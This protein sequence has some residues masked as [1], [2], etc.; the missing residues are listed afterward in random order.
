MA[1]TQDRIAA[2]ITAAKT[3]ED[4]LSSV[5]SVIELF[6]KMVCGNVITGADAIERLH[7]QFG[8]KGMPLDAVA[9]V[10]REFTRYELTHRRNEYMKE[11]Q[12]KRRGASRAPSSDTGGALAASSDDAASANAMSLAE[13]ETAIARAS[14]T[15]SNAASA[16]AAPGAFGAPSNDATTNLPNNAEPSIAFDAELSAD[17]LL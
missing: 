1:I 15:P 17:D 4:R 9:V 5:I 7:S 10:A 16:N 13:I 3:Y 11:Y 6:H 14:G 8:A 2:L 12:R